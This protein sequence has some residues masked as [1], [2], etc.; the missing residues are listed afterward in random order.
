MKFVRPVTIVITVKIFFLTFGYRRCRQ[1]V[2]RESPC[3]IPYPR[4]IFI[5][6]SQKFLILPR[7]RQKI[8]IN[9][10]TIFV[11]ATCF[12]RAT[13]SEETSAAAA[14][15]AAVPLIATATDRW[16]STDTDAMYATR[17]SIAA[18][19]RLVRQDSPAAAATSRRLNANATASAR[20]NGNVNHGSGSPMK[21]YWNRVMSE[22]E[23]IVGYPASFL[24]LRWLL[25]D[26]IANVA[27]HLRR[28][29]SSNHPL[30]KTAK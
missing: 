9:A 18:A 3:I 7:R 16:H 24:S 19:V 12:L 4:N 22:A 11:I 26:E 6:G 25:S 17:T 20:P 28:M 14:A 23:K 15:A 10:S 30:L 29:V 8:S 13:T 27:L 1:S 5:P 21:P 2:A